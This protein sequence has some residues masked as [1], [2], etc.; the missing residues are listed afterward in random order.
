MIV[1]VFRVSEVTFQAI[2]SKS[3]HFFVFFVTIFFFFEKMKVL[4]VLLVAV[5]SVVHSSSATVTVTGPVDT[6]PTFAGNCTSED[7]VK[8]TKCAAATTP[9]E[10]GSKPACQWC[11]VRTY[12]PATCSVFEEKCT[13]QKSE[14]ATW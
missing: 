5:Q 14:M 2:E 7:Y 11:S 10:C 13:C 9:E 6:Q 1:M 4:F 8:I 3:T 12:N